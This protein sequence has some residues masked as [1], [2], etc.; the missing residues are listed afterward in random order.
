MRID[1][2]IDALRSWRGMRYIR[3]VPFASL[4]LLVLLAHAVYIKF[5]GDND[6]FMTMIDYANSY[7]FITCALFLLSDSV[8]RY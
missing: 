8:C 1:N 5:S 6:I 4:F 3:M 2:R 7:F